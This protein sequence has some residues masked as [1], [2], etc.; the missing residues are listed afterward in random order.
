V[1]RAP[2]PVAVPEDP[3][4]GA[5]WAAIK[6]NEHGIGS[7]GE[8]L[9]SPK[10]A[11]GPAQ[12][13]PG[14]APYAAKLAGLPWDEARYRGDR[15]YNEALGRAYYAEQLHTFGDPDMAAAAYNAG[16]GSASR[17]TGLRGAMRKAAEHGEP[18]NWEAYLPLETQRYVEDFRKRTGESPPARQPGQPSA[19][20]L[21]GDDELTALQRSAGEAEA[22]GLALSRD[23]AA[24]AD[25]P[26]L[27]RELF[28]DD[29]GWADAQA[30]FHQSLNA[31]EEAAGAPLE[32]ETG[33]AVTGEPPAAGGAPAAPDAAGTPITV[34]SY[35]DAYMAGLGRGDM[36]RDRELL[37]FAA[38]NATAIEAEFGRRFA[39]GPPPPLTV[40]QV[41]ALRP[42][43]LTPG[44]KR[45]PLWLLAHGNAEARAAGREPQAVWALRDKQTG[46][47]K[48][49]T[50][51]KQ[52]TERER[53][54]QWGPII[55]TSNGCI[56]RRS[57]PNCARS[58]FASTIPR[59]SRSISPAARA[60]SI[61][62]TA[63]S[64]ITRGTADR[65]RAGQADL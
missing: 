56:R 32:R 10:G 37:Q 21:G 62:P 54:A 22:E 4:F 61:S 42:E 49:W 34:E 20:G 38:N 57:T 19:D 65:S 43:Y 40:A 2:E 1:V 51:K 45:D 30:A 44:A 48:T 64:M 6:G 39:E 12:V 58:R 25:V 9:T 63:S 8:F 26:V 55:S 18:G 15:A 29:Q 28:A 60:R 3:A 50:V 31:P 46:E 27:K 35:V 5:Q 52:A 17:G 59:S 53:L 23:R 7:H 14:T 36:P 41:E 47:I 11:V 16:P 13:M 33:T 24:T